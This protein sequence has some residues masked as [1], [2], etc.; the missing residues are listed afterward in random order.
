[1]KFQKKH[2]YI[3]FTVTL[4]LAAICVGLIP[5]VNVNSDMTKY[6]PDD[7]QMKH[8]LDIIEN[9][10]GGAQ[11]A[12]ADV[13][14]MFN[15]SN[16]EKAE[17]ISAQLARI[18]DVDG[19]K[20]RWDAT[21]T[22]ALFELNV[23]KSVDQKQMGKEI[24]KQYG[25]D[26]VVE[27]S[28]DGNT[29]PISV[30]II[31][32][33]LVI[34]IL[35]VMAQSW[36]E[37]LI[38]LM[39]TGIAVALNIGT[40]AFLPSVSI[41][42]NYIVAILQM[43]LS[44]DYSI[45]M[46]N[47]YRQEQAEV[48]S[49]VET[50]N[51]AVKKSFP[52][53]MSSALTT[54]VG[55]LML[56][57]MRLKI[58]MDLGIV[59][60]KGVVFSLICAFTALPSLLMIFSK[61]LKNTSKKS[62]TL[63]TDGIASFATK[64][65]VPLSCFAILLFISAFLLSQKTPI[66]F[67]M[68]QKS[69]ILEV[70][71]QMNPIVMIYD[72]EEE[73]NVIPLADEIQNHYMVQ[74]VISYPTL[75]KQSYSADNMVAEIKAVTEDFADY[76]PANIEGIDKLTPELMRM[77]Y[78]LRN[79]DSDEMQLTFPEVADFIFS[80]CLENPLFSQFIDD[81]IASQLSLLKDM[82]NPTEAE[83][84]IE[85]F[86][87]E[88]EVTEIT[89]NRSDKVSSETVA[90]TTEATK[91][92]ET[93]EEAINNTNPVSA[94][95][96]EDAPSKKEK[97][98]DNGI[99]LVSFMPKLAAAM[100]SVE[101][102]V[103]ATIVDT[104]KIGMDM[105]IEQM[106][107]FIGSTPYQTKMVFSFSKL[108]KKT[109]TP[110]EYVHLLGDD[111]FKRKALA[112][113]INAE[114]KQGLLMR[115]KIMDYANADKS[116]SATELTS[117][118]KEF[119]IAGITEEKV[120]QIALG[121]AIEALSTEKEPAIPEAATT[122]ADTL[123][124]EATETVT[125]APEIMIEQIKPTEPV[126]PVAAPVVSQADYM[127]EL[128]ADMLYSGKKYSPEQLAGQFKKLGYDVGADMLSLLY[129]YY[130][131][132]YNYND[133]TT[134]TIE[135]LINYGLDTLVNDSR[136]AGFID[137]P[138]RAK[139]S[140]ARGLLDESLGM[141]RNEKHSLMVAVTNL[142]VESAETY[143]FIDDLDS[144]RNKILSKESYTVGESIMYN[145]MKN[146]FSKELRIVTILTILAIFLI[147]A[148]SFKSLIVPIILVMTVMTAVYVNVIFSGIISGTMLYLAYLIVQSI[149]MGA[150]IDY[151]ILFTNYYREY[152]SSYSINDAIKMAYK[153]SIRTVMT[154]GLIMVAAPGAM[155]LMVDDMAI[156]AIVSSLAVGALVAILLIM[157]VLPGLLASFDK[158]AGIK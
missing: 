41:T 116:L 11:M 98:S 74:S 131:S 102:Q 87:D 69:K 108:K 111:L 7:S 144:M 16:K 39:A 40:N 146:G 136:I 132:K 124:A 134:L 84:E 130:G 128:F 95:Q 83:D 56:C 85:L 107:E 92:E 12:G 23:S 10:F 14:A 142:P 76:L 48:R 6:L 79:A 51:V 151:G 99:S 57:F 59:L 145:E 45:V 138:T 112:A 22:H 15:L 155:A 53:I 9:E 55:L 49:E 119:G 126:Q 125:E 50:I 140:S 101:S 46:I 42:T 73:E 104:A 8:G 148:I 97:S 110:L 70:F 28:Q 35:L 62:F 66:S 154:S 94:V 122:T 34:F 100:P 81:D 52:A 158:K 2:H 72:T 120:K 5:L 90:T 36:I 82:L 20:L 141:M 61:A 77:V 31:A 106:T 44:L 24:R 157:T 4:L 47:R 149:L 127:A 147:V 18:P 58:G 114:Q 78:Q 13:K 65:R 86:E 115:M 133:S 43:V 33:F 75:F 89:E 68:M 3:L 150:T 129:S 121:G 32:T 63:A 143:A 105:T 1:M 103:L 29:P 135:E 19:V 123:A 113:F 54:I 38:F 88:S 80:D 71:P 26:V 93:K 27:T 96:K 137:E 64:F 117:L 17:E 91:S 156:S 139:L 109:M 67:N 60:A 153:G 30:L 25:S 152:R 118:L 21:G 37:P